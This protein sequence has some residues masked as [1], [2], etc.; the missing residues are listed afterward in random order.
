MTDYIQKDQFLNSVKQKL[1]K[2]IELYP[3]K[4]WIF[5]EII[6]SQLEVGERL[7]SDECRAKIEFCFDSPLSFDTGGCAELMMGSINEIC[8]NN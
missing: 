2:C 5:E 6:M 8:F 1:D 7:T 4:S 3:S